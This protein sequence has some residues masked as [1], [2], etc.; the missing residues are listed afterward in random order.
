MIFVAQKRPTV[1]PIVLFISI[2]LFYFVAQADEAEN[3]RLFEN[4]Q[5]LNVEGVKESLREK[6]DPNSLWS[7]YR[8]PMAAFEVLTSSLLINKK[9]KESSQ[10]AYEIAQILFMN[11][12]KLNLFD[13]N[14]LFFPI[15]EGNVKLV[16]LLIDHGVSPTKRLEGYTPAELA[17]KYGQQQT[18]QYLLVS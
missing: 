13:T 4:I 14:I 16:G 2:F 10:K 18:Y 9:D 12:A 7:K 8:R 5:S 1:F 15:S 6:A 3:Y 17:L 11:G